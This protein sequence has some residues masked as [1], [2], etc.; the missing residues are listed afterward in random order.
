MTR[1]SVSR[2]TWSVPNHE[3]AS[4]GVMLWP[5]LALSGSWGATHGAARAITTI[6]RPTI[7]PAADRVL[8]RANPASS[9]RIERSVDAIAGSGIANARVEPGIAQIDREVHEDEDH[10][11]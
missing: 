5:K 10:G 11:V 2:P 1:E 4:G 9:R 7:P 6:S 8:R 3:C